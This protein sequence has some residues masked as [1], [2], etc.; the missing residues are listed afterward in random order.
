MIT[1][2]NNPLY[3]AHSYTVHYRMFITTSLFNAQQLLANID[4]DIVM[5]CARTVNGVT[6]PE[7]KLISKAAFPKK[8]F[9]YYDVIDSRVDADYMITKYEFKTYLDV[10]PG[11]EAL[12]HGITVEQKIAIHE[13]YSGNL[14][15]LFNKI[16]QS[17]NSESIHIVIKPFFIL[18]NDG[19]GDPP[20]RYSIVHERLGTILAITSITADYGHQGTNYEI[21]G[22]AL[23]DG[24]ANLPSTSTDLVSITSLSVP[25]NSDLKTVM[26][27]FEDSLNKT[28]QERAVKDTN[29]VKFKRFKYKIILS[30]DYATSDYNYDNCTA[31]GTKSNN[32]D[33]TLKFK[34]MTVPDAI[35]KILGGVTRIHNDIVS[36]NTVKSSPKITNSDGNNVEFRQKFRPYITSTVSKEEGQPNIEILTYTINKQAFYTTNDSSSGFSVNN[37]YEAIDAFE[38]LMFTGTNNN[39]MVY[40]YLFTGKNTDVLDFKLALLNGLI[41]PYV[42]KNMLVTPT[43]VTPNSVSINQSNICGND[44][45]FSLITQSPIIMDSKLNITTKNPK[46]KSQYYDV[47]NRISFVETL[48]FKMTVVGNPL[49]LSTFMSSDYGHE[50][51]IFKR[52]TQPCLFFMNINYPKNG[53]FWSYETNNTKPELEPFWY[54]GL[55]RMLIVETVLE[56]N[57]FYHNIEARPFVSE[58]Q[59]SQQSLDYY[60]PSEETKPDTS[61]VSQAAVTKVLLDDQR[62]LEELNAIRGQRP[63]LNELTKLKGR[64]QNITTRLPAPFTQFKVAAG[65]PVADITITSSYGVWRKDKVPEH[66]GGHYHFGTDIRASAG[67]SVFACFD[68]T[69]IVSSTYITITN[70]Q[71]LSVRFFHVDPID[72]LGTTKK[73]VTKNMKIGTVQSIKQPHVHMEIEYKKMVYNAEQ[74]LNSPKF[75]EGQPD[76]VQSFK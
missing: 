2:Q 36:N 49:L 35:M 14:L 64:A 6:S 57:N 1:S 69:V 24:F 40:D 67:A 72:G 4:E 12:S 39:V 54:Q 8:A 37:N 65:T 7:R 21:S 45:P 23:E 32:N 74:V 61:S 66:H 10:Q 16:A 71:G 3:H 59:Q 38:K 26:Q 43:A 15:L 63:L 20:D 48:Q 22:A 55:M 52:D 34:D 9:E 29:D 25:K 13:A 58:S 28:A 18:A 31:Y 60:K 47:L 75:K 51:N 11:T 46:S 17:S 76:V 42:T 5:N 70:P 53:N 73:I 27:T 30:D 62:K 68:G 56:G 41:V 50:K 44:N 19:G 33:P